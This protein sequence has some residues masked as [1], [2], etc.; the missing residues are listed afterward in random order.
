MYVIRCAQSLTI[1]R[2]VV[3][4]QRK[5]GSRISLIDTQELSLTVKYSIY[6]QVSE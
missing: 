4:L 6:R 1:Q 5:D 2:G 3:D